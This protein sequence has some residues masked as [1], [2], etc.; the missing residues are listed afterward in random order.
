[1][2]TEQVLSQ[3]IE[4]YR[5]ALHNVAWMVGA[6]VAPSVAAT[7]ANIAAALAYREVRPTRPRPYTA[8]DV[9]DEDVE[10]VRTAVDAAGLPRG[11]GVDLADIVAA[12]WNRL[13]EKER[14]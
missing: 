2:S 3:L 14:A 4:D 10:A 6:Q 1:M 8:A 5:D 11:G 13:R 12:A 7:E 9:T